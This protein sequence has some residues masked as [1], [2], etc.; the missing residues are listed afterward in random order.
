MRGKGRKPWPTG[1]RRVMPA[2]RRRDE[3]E[4][5]EI[6]VGSTVSPSRV[7][8]GMVTGVIAGFFASC[9]FV[10]MAYHFDDREQ[11]ERNFPGRRANQE[12]GLPD[13]ARAV[14]ELGQDWYSFA[15]RVGGR[16]RRFLYH[17]EREGG[18]LVELREEGRP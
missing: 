9:L 4:R 2:P 6:A 16:E 14:E 5:E 15:L 3:G 17:G 18:A 8:E 7:G 13:A 10:G 11:E 12:R 1:S